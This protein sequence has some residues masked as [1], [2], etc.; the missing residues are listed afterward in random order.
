[1]KNLAQEARQAVATFLAHEVSQRQFA[2]ITQIPLG[3][4][5]GWEQGVR[6]PRYSATETLLKLISQSTEVIVPALVQLKVEQRLR[7]EIPLELASEI[8]DTVL[9]GNKTD[10]ERRKAF[11]ALTKKLIRAKKISTAGTFQ[12]I[13]GVRY[14]VTTVPRFRVVEK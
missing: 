13:D 10:S 12:V 1:M 8:V 5:R 14:R 4:I 2:N 6:I 9:R 3:T 11:C 7:F